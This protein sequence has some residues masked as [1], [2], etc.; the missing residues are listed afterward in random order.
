MKVQIKDG[1]LVISMPL[2]HIKCGLENHQY[3]PIKITDIKEMGKVYKK[4]ITN[5]TMNDGHTT[6]FEDMLDKIGNLAIENGE[7]GFDLIE[8]A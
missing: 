5:E 1:N 8:G 4:Y 7:D 3:D 2:E 6:V